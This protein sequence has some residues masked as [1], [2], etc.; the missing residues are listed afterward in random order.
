M[1]AP[2]WYLGPDWDLKP[3]VCPEPD[4]SMPP[5]R[6]G[7]I[8]Q[9]LSGARSMTVTGV[10]EQYSFDFEFLDPNEYHRLEALH[11]RIIPGP[12]RLVN[13]LRVNRLSPQGAEVKPVP[14]V[15]TS[16]TGVSVYRGLLSQELDWPLG[17]GSFGA[18]STKW[19]IPVGSGNYLRFDSATKF[20][21]FPQENIVLSVFMKSP[22][23]GSTLRMAIDWFD[24]FGQQV[25][26]LSSPATLTSDWFRF[27]IPL[28]A[29]AGICSARF[30]LT[31]PS[32]DLVG[33]HV[34]LAAAQVE[35]GTVTTPWSPGG[36][37]P[38]VLIDQLDTVSPRA[39]YYNTTL[40]VLEA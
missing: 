30:A 6:Y 12:H 21:V 4:I 25:S 28:T 2:I 40:T 33:S 11:R 14:G 22:I 36:G 38:R 29:P 10:K 39:P 17:A 31:N 19:S 7:G 13:P 23:A 8:F 27:S 34:Q 16:R 1:S 18:L 32:S 37:A 35:T 15:V 24:K 9:G 20:P 26:S 3:L 5:V